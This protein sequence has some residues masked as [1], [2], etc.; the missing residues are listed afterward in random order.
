MRLVWCTWDLHVG[1]GSVSMLQDGTWYGSLRV[2]LPLIDPLT[3]LQ[4]RVLATD[5]T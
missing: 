2:K 3:N 5:A 1:K 4:Q